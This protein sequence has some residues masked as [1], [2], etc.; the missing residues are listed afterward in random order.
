M[1]RRLYSPSAGKWVEVEPA[2]VPN[3]P[4]KP[5]RPKSHGFVMVP[6]LWR[7]RL[8][9]VNAGGVVYHVAMVILDLSR[10]SEWV[11]LSNIVVGVDRHAKYDAI[12]L[13]RKVGLILVE[14]QGGKAPRVKA[15]FRKE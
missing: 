11:V 9:E 15:L 7:L 1:T 10:W 13:L 4:A 14:G 2:E 3:T 8:R 5:K 12:E 6:N